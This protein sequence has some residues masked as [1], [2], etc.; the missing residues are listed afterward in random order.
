ME[1][2]G[3]LWHRPAI[4]WILWF[5]QLWRKDIMSF[6]L[7]CWLLLLTAILLT[8]S[9]L[10]RAE[11]E[12]SPVYRPTLQIS[13]AA[14]EI[15][16]DGWLN[17]PGW[18]G[19]T[20]ASHFVEM[21]PGDNIKPPTETQAMLTY[22]DRYL[23]VAMIAQSDGKPLRASFCERDQ[24]PGDDNL[25]IFIDTYGD[26]SWAY[27]LFVNAYG[28]QYDA[29]WTSSIGSDTK[30]D[31]VWES[32]GKVTDSG[33]Q[34]ELAIPFSSLRFPNQPKQEWRVDFFRY[35]ER[36]V[37][38]E[39][40]W[41]AYD[42]EET[43]WPCQWGTVTGIE[44]VTPG[45]GIEI[46]P[47]AIGYQSGHS[48]IISREADG[49]TDSLGW[50]NKDPHGEMSL[51]TKY[52]ISS[53]ATAELAL[54][55]DFSQVEADADQIDVNST[56]ALSFPEKRPFFQEGRDLFQTLYDVVYTRSIND[57]AVA[58]KLTF[59]KGATRIGY[60]GAYDEHSPVMIPFVDFSSPD[61]LSGKSTSNI[62][63]V[64]Q[65]IGEN[66]QLGLL[67]TDR[68]FDNGGGAGTAVSVD[69]SIR[70]NK[71]LQFQGQGIVSHTTEPNDTAFT[72]PG[73]LDWFDFDPTTNLNDQVFDGEHTAGF[74]GESFWGHA[75]IGILEYNGSNFYVGPR[76]SESSPTFRLDN[77]YQP[78]CGR[79]QTTLV[80][81]YKF[82]FDHGLVESITPQMNVS[83]IWDFNGAA[84]DK[85]GYFD[86]STNL[87][88][89][90]IGLHT[91]YLASSELY[92]GVRFSG[93]WSLHQ[94]ASA[95]PSGSI[96]F[97]G[98]INIG[99]QPAY[100]W[101]TM[102]RQTRFGLWCDFIL[103]D[104]VQ[105]ENTYTHLR[106]IAKETDEQLYSGYI[107]Y[108][109]M[110]VQFSRELS[111]RCVVQ[112]ND[113][114][115]TWDFDPLIT[116]RLNPFTLFYVGTTYN[117]QKD[118]GLNREGTSYAG[119]GEESY[120]MNRLQSRQFFMKLQYLFQL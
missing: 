36:E 6:R 81:Y 23:Y 67:T 53:S 114:Y 54:N 49:L 39:I 106:S 46:I 17:D 83:K 64:R 15:K 59:R 109:K 7:P 102:G 82:R 30:Y 40:S 89:Y 75:F 19:V 66:S 31:L 38:R 11:D 18:Q 62:L 47:A 29:I 119:D 63:S 86:L 69:G 44:N 87:R 84:K 10:A 50:M 99:D 25:G 97:G 27:E 107:A 48:A 100:G 74:D 5:E 113:F 8:A 76:Y 68:R 70:L 103:F 14:G 101:L 20:V 115:E 72:A 73:Y 43:C 33:F 110:S 108:S 80:S 104:R 71:S 2:V 4:G 88:K 112:Y 91:Q 32:A 61:L 98:N 26:A 58:A 96:A 93:I 94:C 24:T 45:K 51:S 116:Y 120:D 16:V 78:R 34:V 35:H 52:S 9:G 105:F 37:S 79:K 28:V 42:R 1:R 13:R 85:Y 56:T 57:P 3:E 55:P 65:S 41:S 90:Q 21:S 117:Y 95:A 12:F 22:D 77:G 92:R 118:Y 111:L 60:L